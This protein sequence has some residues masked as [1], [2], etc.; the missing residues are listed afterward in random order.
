MRKYNC[1]D[2]LAKLLD[3]ADIPYE[4][5]SLWDGEQIR[6]GEFDAVCHEYS[7]GHMG[8]IIGAMIFLISFGLPLLK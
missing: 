4:R 1:I 2:K 6:V 8:K 5:N 7:K 3:E